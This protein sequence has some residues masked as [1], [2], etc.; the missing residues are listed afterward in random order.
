MLAFIALACD[1]G[2]L[3]EGF[4]I[5][6][7]AKKLCHLFLLVSDKTRIRRH[8]LIN[9]QKRSICL[10]NEKVSRDALRQLLT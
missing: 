9:A 4:A 6:G 1:G 10:E 8:S 3:T 5:G 7:K 2:T